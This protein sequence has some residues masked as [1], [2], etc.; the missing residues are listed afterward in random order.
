VDPSTLS[1]QAGQRTE[2]CSQGAEK[3]CPPKQTD[4]K[5]G[6]MGVR[7]AGGDRDSKHSQDEPTGEHSDHNWISAAARHTVSGVPHLG[8]Y[9]AFA[10]VTEISDERR[11]S[12]FL[13]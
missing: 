5:S 2:A 8:A 12:P 10:F 3:D 9:N 13:I 11:D 7:I 4:Y 1:K 6:W